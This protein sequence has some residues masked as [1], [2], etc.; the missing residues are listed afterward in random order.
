[1]DI[2]FVHTMETYQHAKQ[3]FTRASEDNFDAEKSWFFIKT[4]IQ[5]G[6]VQTVFVDNV[7]QKYLWSVAKEELTPEQRDIIFSWPHRETSSKAIFQYWP[8]HR[9]HFHVRFKCPP[10]Q[11]ACRN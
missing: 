1:M 7:V 6:N 5:T 8:G 11:P 3:H 4:L 10:D 9:N 2:G